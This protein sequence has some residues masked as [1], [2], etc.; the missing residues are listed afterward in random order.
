MQVTFE[1]LMKDLQA[2]Q[3]AP[4]YFLEG[5]EPFF[6]DKVADYIEEHALEAAQKDFNLTVLYGKDVSMVDVY[7][8]AQRYPMFSDRQVVMV[9]EAQHLFPNNMKE[10]ESDLLLNYLKQPA[11]TTMLV[12]C[13][14]YKNLDKR[15][16]LSKQ[17][18]EKAV[19]LDA[20]KIKENAL[21]G[22]ITLLAKKNGF[23]IEPRTTHLL[24]DYLG[25]DLSRIVNEFEKLKLLLPA[26][27]TITSEAVEEHI[28][29]SKEFNSY[30]L[31]DALMHKN[32]HKCMRILQ[33]FSH[34][35]N[36]GPM[37]LIMG[38]LYNQFSKLYV[39]HHM[40][41][42]S[43]GEIASKAGMPSFLVGNYQAASKRY[44]LSK[45][46]SALS[47]LSEYDLRS[48]GVNNKGVEQH[49]LMQELIYKI[50]FN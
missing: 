21:P 48:K 39:I 17:I 46:E 16:T 29:I 34:N 19:Y 47:L 7:N 6:I 25:N 38:S 15:K 11:A 33:Y 12:F 50:I 41:G 24:S 45:V 35:P 5:E 32:F 4:L 2:G 23:G 37:P 27:A 42:A 9:R 13:H 49:E 18:R 31:S 26:G 30:E 20:Q 36:A 43:D 14:K 10:S 1:A 40:P 44:S 8:A 28:G 3:Y 22:W